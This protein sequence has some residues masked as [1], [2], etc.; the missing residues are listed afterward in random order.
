MAA[1]KKE[2][3]L[4]R[5]ALPKNADSLV[6]WRALISKRYLILSQNAF[7]KIGIDIDA[8]S[9]EEADKL[10]ETADPKQIFISLGGFRELAEK[11]GISEVRYDMIFRD[12]DLAVYRCT[13]HFEPNEENPNGVIYCGVGGASPLNTEP[14]FVKY[15]DSIAENRAF[16]RA[17]RNY[18]RIESLGQEE[19]EPEQ[20]VEV[21]KINPLPAGKLQEVMEKYNMSF[22]DLKVFGEASQYEWKDWKH[23]GEIPGPVAFSLIGAISAAKK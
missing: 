3:P 13:I 16:I 15:L 20:K 11:R 8:L 10:K 17:V 21:S 1:K 2:T 22:E 7:A 12:S 14:N 19:V 23:V 9:Q 18:F 5:P 6:D 4:L